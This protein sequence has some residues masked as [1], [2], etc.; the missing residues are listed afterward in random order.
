MLA[1]E[2]APPLA[3]VASVS[4]ID[5]HR[6]IQNHLFTSLLHINP[7]GP[8]LDRTS[9]PSTIYQP[10]RLRGLQFQLSRPSS[11]ST[12]PSWLIYPKSSAVGG[13]LWVLVHSCSFYF[14]DVKLNFGVRRIDLGGKALTEYLKA[15]VSHH[16][17]RELDDG[18]LMVDVKQKLCFFSLY[19]ACNLQVAR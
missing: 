7:S 3:G 15:L 14:Q 12:R 19:I 2:L 1:V 16:S 17:V 11:L 9:L 6:D 5:P 10:T 13:G 4:T 8:S 18:F